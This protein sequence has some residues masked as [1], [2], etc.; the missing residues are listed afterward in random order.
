[1]VFES[2]V[3]VNTVTNWRI[4]DSIGI[5]DNTVFWFSFT[6][7]TD[8]RVTVYA[9]VVVF[10]LAIGAWTCW[11]VISSFIIT[12]GASVISGTGSTLVVTL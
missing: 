3:S 6:S 8:I 5:T 9:C 2:V 12:S 1:V 7:E 11:W 10:V 4:L